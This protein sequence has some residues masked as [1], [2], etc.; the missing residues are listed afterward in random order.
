MDINVWV[1]DLLKKNPLVSIKGTVIWGLIIT[2]VLA[3]I[4][5]GTA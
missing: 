2:V 5:K 3:V 4:V 1:N